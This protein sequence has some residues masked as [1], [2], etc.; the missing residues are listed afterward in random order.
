MRHGAQSAAHRS[1][2]TTP[3]KRFIQHRGQQHVEFGSHLRLQL[4][5]GIGFRLQ[6][7]EVGHDAP[8][9][10][11]GGLLRLKRIGTNSRHWQTVDGTDVCPLLR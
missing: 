1:V 8:L 5:H 9:L 10:I 6:A 2:P 3:P 7:I 4:L 11:G